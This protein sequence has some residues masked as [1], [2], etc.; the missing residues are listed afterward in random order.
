MADEFTVIV[1]IED[2]NVAVGVNAKDETTAID[3]VREY[4]LNLGYTDPSFDVLKKG[5]MSDK[6]IDSIPNLVDYI[7][8]VDFQKHSEALNILMS[9]PINTMEKILTE[10]SQSL[11]LRSNST[12]LKNMIKRHPDYN[13]EKEIGDPLPVF[14]LTAEDELFLHKYGIKG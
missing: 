9:L 5:H 2:F 8:P 7:D 12:L 1:Q 6:D 11:A 4:I 10:S 13:Q 14:S 3:L